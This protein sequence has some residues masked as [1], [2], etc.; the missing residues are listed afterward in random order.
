MVKLSIASFNSNGFGEDRIKIMADLCKSH[1]FVLL[2]EHW[3]LNN[4][5]D[6]LSAIPGISLLAVSEMPYNIL[7]FFSQ[8]DN[9][10]AVLYYGTR[11]FMV[12]WPVQ[13]ISSR[14]CGIIVIINDMNMLL[15]NVHMPT[16]TKFNKQFYLE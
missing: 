16:D 13:F 4:Q 7:L 14:I 8:V 11:T 10:V 15:A 6:K 3:L 9:I 5:L 12:L 1:S 2:Q